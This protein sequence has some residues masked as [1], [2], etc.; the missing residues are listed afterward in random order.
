MQPQDWGVGGVPLR[1]LG[2]SE[3]PPQPFLPWFPWGLVLALWAARAEPKWGGVGVLLLRP[4]PR[5]HPSYG[6]AG[7]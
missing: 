4:A 7:G 3:R 6:P 2:L 5:F 1:F